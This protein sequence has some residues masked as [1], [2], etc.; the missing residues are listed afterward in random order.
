MDY[1]PYFMS[2]DGELSMWAS[3]FS[4]RVLV[5]ETDVP[6]DEDDKLLR[7]V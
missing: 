4:T 3:F 1:T 6:G 7:S 5:E 2:S